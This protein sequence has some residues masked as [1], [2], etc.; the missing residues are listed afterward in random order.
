VLPTAGT[1]R[2]FSV[3]GV[4]DF[5]K[6]TS[7]IEFSERGFHRL[8]PAAARLARL[9]GL[10]AHSRALEARKPEGVDPGE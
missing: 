3:L 6:R 1:A 4:E 2:F 5:Q 9:E 7:L 10:F 8:A